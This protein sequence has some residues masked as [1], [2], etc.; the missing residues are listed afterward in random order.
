MARRTYHTPRTNRDISPNYIYYPPNPYTV[1]KLQNQKSRP[2]YVCRECG[3][4]GRVRWSSS[5]DDMIVE[6]SNVKCGS[7]IQMFIDHQ[8][9]I[10]GMYP[11]GEN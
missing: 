7:F 8:C 1:K 6:C 11:R 2:K 9:N 5:H 3:A 10:V 4:E